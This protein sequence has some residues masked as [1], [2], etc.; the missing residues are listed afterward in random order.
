MKTKYILKMAMR[1]FSSILAM[2]LLFCL[3]A[4]GG[5]SPEKT[6]S[7]TVSGSDF[8]NISSAVS[9]SG[10]T[11][12]ISSQ[13]CFDSAMEAYYDQ[14]NK[15]K[16]ETEPNRTEAFMSCFFKDIDGNGI[17]ELCVKHQSEIKIY[18]FSNEKLTEIGSHDF[19]TGT[20]R[21]FS[22]EDSDY[23]GIFC[24]T[25]GGS[26]E[27]YKYLTIK[28]N[29]L[30]LEYIWRDQ[31]AFEEMGYPERTDIEYT[32]DKAMIEESKYLYDNNKDVE[33]LKFYTAG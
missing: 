15:I 13:P 25:A 8:I 27:H 5:E 4:C 33:M 32:T 28:D 24:F 20:L 7:T 9:D 11:S 1:I 23:P 31:F 19:S 29:E 17:D 10:N 14:L 30:S 3:T 21:I 22:S 18:T 26:A 2:T 16:D 6:A 12:L